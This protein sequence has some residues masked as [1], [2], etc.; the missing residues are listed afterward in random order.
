M[1]QN[2]IYKII[3]SMKFINASSGLEAK[4]VNV[5]VFARQ[6]KTLFSRKLAPHRN[7]T[8][9]YEQRLFAGELIVFNIDF[10][11]FYK[12]VIRSCHKLKHTILLV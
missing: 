7:S 1:K 10:I 12:P 6:C 11:H 5:I 4:N 3:V 2:C 9:T 8:L